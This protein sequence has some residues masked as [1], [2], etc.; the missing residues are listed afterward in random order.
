MKRWRGGK[1]L[2]KSAAQLTVPKWTAISLCAV[3]MLSLVLPLVGNGIT[4]MA[5]AAEDSTGLCPHHKS[6]D[7]SCGWQPAKGGLLSAM[8]MT[9][10]AGTPHWR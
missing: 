8:F 10:A 4:P 6:H 3:L 7:E 5:F 2:R 9:K 1:R